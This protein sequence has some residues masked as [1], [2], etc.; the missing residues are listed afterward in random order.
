MTPRRALALLPGWLA[1]AMLAAIAILPCAAQERT[2][3]GAPLPGYAGYVNDHAGVLDE[4]ARAKLESF[5][6]QLER[7]TGAQFAVL[8]VRT[9]EPLYPADY[10]VQ[11]FQQ[12]GI[13]RKGQDSGLLMLVAIEQR[14][15]EFETGYGLEG[16]LPDGLQSRIVRREVAPRFREGDW[17]GGVT[18]GV[19]ACASR[20][21]A[22]KGVTLSWNG[23]E[24]RY[25]GRRSKPGSEVVIAILV[26]LIIAGVV[27]SMSRGGPYGP[28]GRRRHGG[29]YGGW[30]G[31]WGG[32]FGGG[33]GG[34]WGGGGFG[35]G[36]SGGSS[37]G[38]FGGGGSGG[39]GGGGSW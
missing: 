9:T 27:S 18:A 23:E 21:A 26:F 25:T 24:L 35:G 22:E 39:G 7:K 16:T 19:L 17:A 33:L 4:P 38:G 8:I 11:V 34:G 6:D 5:L 37:F 12:W 1:I 20:I 13:G 2:D 36:D 29:W 14:R 3:D 30:G 32:G 15:V 10:K 31:G 28:T